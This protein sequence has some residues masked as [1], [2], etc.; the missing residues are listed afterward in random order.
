MAA[1]AGFGL[2]DDATPWRRAS[3]AYAT[4][5]ALLA[6]AIPALAS[7]AALVARQ[8]MLAILVAIVGVVFAARQL[9]IWRHAH[10]ALDRGQIFTRHGWLAPS[11]D[12][13]DEIKVQSVELAQG[14]LARRRGYAT[15]NFGIAG[16][17]L[18][19]HGVLLADARTIAARVADTAAA[20]DFSDLPR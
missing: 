6:L 19:M 8:P 5:R 17:T 1:E 15:I 20:V 12:I 18:A 16:G 11:L 4:D 2:P 14:P 9:F 7:G 13:G 10:H 3:K